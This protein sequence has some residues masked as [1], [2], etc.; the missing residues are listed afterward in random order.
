MDPFSLTIGSLACTTIAVRICSK[1]SNKIQGLNQAPATVSHIIN[2]VTT[3]KLLVSSIRDALDG[4][5]GSPAFSQED[6]VRMQIL[7]EKAKDKLLQIEMVLEYEMINE[8]TDS[9]KIITSR[10]STVRNEK[11]VLRLRH[12]F[13]DLTNAIGTICNSIIIAGQVQMQAA[14]LASQQALRDISAGVQVLVQAQHRDSGNDVPTSGDIESIPDTQLGLPV[15]REDGNQSQDLSSQ[16]PAQA[17]C[18]VFTLS[19]LSKPKFTPR[20]SATLPGDAKVFTFAIEGDLEGLKRLFQEK[21]AS[22]HDI[23]MSTGRTALHYGIVYNHKDVCQFLLDQGADSQVVD[24][25]KES[26]IH[27][28]WTRI[29]G[30]LADSSTSDAFSNMFDDSD[31]FDSRQFPPFHKIILGLNGANLACQLELTGSQINDRDA[32]GR[33]ALSWAA[34]R[35]DQQ[36]VL[37]LLQ[38]KANPNIAADDGRTPLHWAAN[39]SNPQTVKTLLEYRADTEA[40]DLWYRT[41]IQY[42]ACNHAARDM[43]DARYVGNLIAHGADVDAQD[44]HQRTALGYAAKHNHHKSLEYLLR[45]G[46]ETSIADNWGFSPLFETAK[47]TH[48]DSLRLLMQ[49]DATCKGETI[50]KQ[51]LLHLVA[52]QGSR[53]TMDIIGHHNLAGLDWE[54][55]DVKG[56]TARDL[57]QKRVPQANELLDIFDTLARTE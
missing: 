52:V 55:R 22:P 8:R 36:A 18:F 40:R 9:G 7:F 6:R 47:A 23:A 35:G 44:C 27:I 32:D 15:K 51:S 54:M 43:D 24:T 14:M 53:E 13:K 33:T 28:A 39:S 34:A 26:A 21:A 31:Y 42:A 17:L 12:D 25:H 45:N 5:A 37:Q 3:F 29:F 49:Y 11:E 16:D 41:P 1:A 4:T 56:R 30:K 50:Q 57:L 19:S 10:T 46:A 48:H 2:D 20:W 38:A